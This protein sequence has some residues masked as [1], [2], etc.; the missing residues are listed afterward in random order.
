VAAAVVLVQLELEVMQEHRQLLV[1]A[2]QQVEVMGELEVP[3]M[4]M[5]LGEVFMA[6]AAAVVG[7]TNF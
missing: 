6:V 7:V 2:R 4:L 1:Q 3:Q 5:A